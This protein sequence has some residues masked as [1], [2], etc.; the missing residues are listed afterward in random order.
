MKQKF[1]TALSIEIDGHI[2]GA[3][4]TVELDAETAK[5]YQHALRV[6]EDA[7]EEK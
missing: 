3:G 1:V 5:E 2:Y 7:P 6:V 4:E